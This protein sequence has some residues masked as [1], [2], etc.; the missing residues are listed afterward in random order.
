VQ[1]LAFVS[2]TLWIPVILSELNWISLESNWGML[3][4][5][6]PELFSYL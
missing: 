2:E 1:S 3:D 5:P 4:A 6:L